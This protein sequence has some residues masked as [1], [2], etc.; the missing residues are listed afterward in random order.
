MLVDP[1]VLRTFADQVNIAANAI[2]SDDVGHKV[3]TAADG[4]GGST[5]QWAARLVGEHL[6]SLANAIATNIDH[7]G[8]AVRGV[9]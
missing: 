2:R 7:M 6:G 9:S 5:T 8:T 3:T 1:D 4:L